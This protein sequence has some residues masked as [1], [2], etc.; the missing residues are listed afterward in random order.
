MR[1]LAARLGDGPGP[2]RG[3]RFPADSDAGR[4]CADAAARLRRDAGRRPAPPA[5]PADLGRTPTGTGTTQA[6]AR[7][8]AARPDPRG[9]R[10]GRAGSS[11]SAPTSAPRTNLG[12]WVNKVGVWSPRERPDWFADDAETILHWREQ[13]TGQHIELG[14]AETNLVGLLGELGA[15]WSRWGE[16]L[17]PIGVLYDPFV[18]RALEPWSFGIYA[19]G[20]SILVGTPSG[21]TLAPGGRRAPVDHHAV[22][23][24]RAARLHHL[25]A[26]VRPRHRVVPARRRWPGWAGPT[27]SSAY[28]RLSTRPV[29]QAL[30]AVPTDPAAR[31]RRR[32]QVVAGAYPLRRAP[33]GPAVTIAAMGAMVPE[34][35]AAA[36]RLDALGVAADVVFVT[37]PDLLFRAVQGGGRRVL[38]VTD[39]TF[40]LAQGEHVGLVG[41]SGSGKTVLS[42]ALLGYVSRPGR[43][44]SGQVLIN[45]EDILTASDERRRSLRGGRLALVPQDATSALTPVLR[46]RELMAETIKAHLDVGPTDIRALSLKHL[47]QVGIPSPKDRLDA[48]PFELSGGMKQRLAIALALACDPSVLIADE[49]TSAVDVTIQA[50]ILHSFASSGD[51][52]GLSIL[53]VSHDLRVVSTLCSRVMVL[54]AGRIVEEGTAART[55][56]TPRHQYTNALLK[57]SPGVDARRV[58]LATVPGSPPASPSDVTGCPFHPRC[59]RADARCAEVM[60]PDDVD[61]HGRWACW[62]P[63]S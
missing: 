37:S 17:L 21:V 60:P 28:L 15:T 2:T 1:E 25:R 30:A 45:G 57:C 16:P 55:L 20:Q 38:D 4:L 42:Q 59:P 39:I 9:A 11:P 50:Q 48:Y 47:E 5:V 33:S 41:E 7:P 49:P 8:G 44:V 51:R 14:I 56:N 3:R 24:A 62:H 52:I 32:R 54:Y 26:R 31:E 6:G 53:L 63:A 19:G 18:D 46:I 35:L 12:G 22:D 36:D 40:D 10:G 58:P 23:R 27:A 43:I 29:D 13:P 61:A 34:A